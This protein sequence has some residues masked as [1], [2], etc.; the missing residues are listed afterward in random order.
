MHALTLLCKKCGEKVI[1]PLKPTSRIRTFLCP[2]ESCGGT[3]MIFLSAEP[4]TDR[5][6]IQTV[7]DLDDRVCRIEAYLHDQDDGFQDYDPK[8]KSH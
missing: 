8:G 7:A 5:G 1:W 2:Q 3:K 4:L 6:F